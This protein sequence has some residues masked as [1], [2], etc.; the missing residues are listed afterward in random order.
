MDTLHHDP[1]V[2][3]LMV[4]SYFLLADVSWAAEAVSENHLLDI[5]WGFCNLTVSF[6]PTDRFPSKLVALFFKGVLC[7]LGLMEC[8][9]VPKPM[10]TVRWQTAFHLHVQE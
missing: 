7:S 8:P 5:L 3:F 1:Q 6:L 4:A 10:E 2:L 9:C